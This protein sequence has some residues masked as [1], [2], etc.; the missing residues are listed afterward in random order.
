MTFCNFSSVTYPHIRPSLSSPS[1]SSPIMSS[2]AMSSLS[3]S[4]PPLSSPSTSSPPLSSPVHP[5]EV[6]R[7][8]PPLKERL[9]IGKLRKSREGKG[10]AMDECFAELFRGPGYSNVPS[11]PI[12]C[13]SMNLRRHTARPI[14][15]TAHCPIPPANGDSTD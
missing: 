13:L 15:H 7:Q 14:Q 1:M 11:G 2:P 5:C 9:G 6:V 10:R 3:M 12:I 4:S 8:C